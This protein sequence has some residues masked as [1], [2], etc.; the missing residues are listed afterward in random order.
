M[1]NANEMRRSTPYGNSKEQSHSIRT[2]VPRG[3]ALAY[4]YIIWPD[5]DVTVDR[6]EVY[7]KAIEVVTQ[8]IAADPSIEDAA[9]TVYGFIYHKR[10]DWVAAAEAFE[11]AIN[12]DSVEPIAH[13]WYSRA[14]AS[15]GRLEDALDHAQRAMELDP[16]H[17]DQAVIISRMAIASFWLNDLET[18]QRYFE[19]A[20]T[21][22]LEAP[23]H[24]LAYSLFLIRTG[25]FAS[26][27]SYAK[28]GLEQN[29]LPSGWVDDVFAGLQHEEQRQHAIDIVAQV[30]AG[31]ELQETV[32][33]T[34]WALFD[35]TDRAM[36]VAR[37]LEQNRGILELEIIFV[38][39]FRH[40]R[41]HP[42]FPA[43][44]DAIGLNDYWANAG[45]S[46]LNDKVVCTDA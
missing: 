15:V 31:G 19:I 42:E 30:S 45:C 7:D 5:Y 16:S 8:G 39:E 1:K 32:E 4:T 28:L 37:R 24:S 40:F 18:A 26:A 34:L 25:Q 38:E 13:A 14:L 33:L 27:A 22:Q 20:S 35:E 41:Q 46:W 2:T 36:R 17:P 44:V 6:E 11:Q 10:N 12:A 3:W 43:F 21:M 9:G 23:I 29:G